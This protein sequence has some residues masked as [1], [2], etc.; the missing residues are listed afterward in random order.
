MIIEANRIT[1]G[2]RSYYP[3]AVWL[4]FELK[5]HSID[6]TVERYLVFL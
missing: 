1:L 3:D 4:R 2:Q 5:E 6:E